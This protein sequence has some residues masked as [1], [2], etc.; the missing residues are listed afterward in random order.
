VAAVC[1][2]R[3]VAHASAGLP[4]WPMA[5]LL[6]GFP[7][8]WVLGLAPFMPVALALVMI[9]LLVRRGDAA[10][11]A[12]VVPLAVLLVWTVPCA[13]M[14][15]SGVRLVGWFLRFG[16]LLTV[17][18]VV[19][20]VV[21]ARQHVTRE[22]LLDAMVVVWLTVVVG[23]WLAVL[24]PQ[25]Q[26]ATPVGHLLPGALT[27]NDLV[28]R[29]LFP[30][31]AEVQDP[32]GAPSPFARPAAPFP[33]ANS[34]GAAVTFLTPVVIAAFAQTRSVV[35]RVVIA[36]GMLAVVVPVV[37]ASNRGTLL[38]LAVAGGY[39]LLRTVA[40]GHVRAAALTGGVAIAGGA[41]LVAAGMLD[42]IS[43][44]QQYS[45]ST[46]TRSSLYAETL[47]R[48]LASPIL[49]WGGP[50]PSWHHDVSV[51]TQGLMW[52]V[53]FSYGFV[54]LALLLAHVVW[55]VVRTRRCPAPGDLLL[56]SVLVSALVAIGFYG[57]DTMQWTIVAI[58]GAVLLRDPTARSGQRSDAADQPTPLGRGESEGDSG[59]HD[60]D[61][62]P[63][64]RSRR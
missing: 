35:R 50:R 54:G 49:G 45:D 53:L 59:A 13:L 56:H 2:E 60:A 47:H 18:T 21:T 52:Q 43:T 23:G 16:T 28:H 22:R 15:D 61:A 34:W 6:H 32:W 58:A 9:G 64:V 8:W 46:G 1:D 36:V 38:C 57:L 44:R 55:L 30:A 12:P 27:G 7:L 25:G 19:V 62:L 42:S 20:Y 31:F 4:W 5:A 40:R 14:L 41:V 33:Y 10:L 63:F 3:P 37:Q 11:P 29:L 26:F 51:G 24:A 48:V 39:V 17:A